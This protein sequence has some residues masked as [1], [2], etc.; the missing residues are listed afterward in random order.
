MTLWPVLAVIIAG[1]GLAGQTLFLV[2][3][4]AVGYCLGYLVTGYGFGFL[5]TKTLFPQW[6]RSMALLLALVLTIILG[7]TLLIPVSPDI[8]AYFGWVGKSQGSYGAF[9]LGFV[10][11]FWGMLFRNRAFSSLFPTTEEE[12]H[13]RRK[14][15]LRGIAIVGFILVAFLILVLIISVFAALISYIVSIA[16]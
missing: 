12:A 11:A 2:V 15:T 8:K 9:A 14:N 1:L 3:G 7:L 10:L 5:T 6:V 16:T 4:F 13:D